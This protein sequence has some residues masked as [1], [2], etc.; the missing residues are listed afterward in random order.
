MFACYFDASGGKDIGVTI[1]S[2][3]I[4]QILQWDL[5]DADWRILLAKYNVPYFHMREFAHSK[6]PFETWKGE[7]NKRTNFLRLAAET[8]ASRA[9]HGFTCVVEH[10]TYAKVDAE[11]ELSESVGNPYSMAARDCIA[12]ANIWLRKAERGIPVQYVF[13]EGDPGQGLLV[14]IIKK[15]NKYASPNDAIDIPT[16][17]PSRDRQGGAKGLTQLQAA[18]FAAYEYLKAYRLGEDELLYKYRK[19]IRALSKIPAWA[20]RYTNTDIITMCER[21][22]IKKRAKQ[23]AG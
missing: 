2:G 18:D 21:A 4:G 23:V 1:V 6:G 8:I 19:S 14:R 15:H 13:D 17:R 11:Y 3:W 7:E 20:G 5:F 9:H 10:D 16:F 22:G 12:H